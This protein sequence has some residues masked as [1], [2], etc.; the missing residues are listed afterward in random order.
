MLNKSNSPVVWIIVK[1][2][3]TDLKLGF[4]TTH[5][6]AKEQYSKIRLGQVKHL[7]KVLDKL[8][9]KCD[10]IICSGDF[11]G[12]P[13]E[14]FYKV[15]TEQSRM[16]SSYKSVLSGEPNW[17]TWKIRPGIGNRNSEARRCIDYVFYRKSDPNNDG[18]DLDPVQILDLPHSLENDKDKLPRNDYP[19][20]HLSL[21]VR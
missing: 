14:P 20:D 8:A 11:N 19:S 2:K 15:M 16:K 3:N 1:D 6:K 10:A 18:F 17:T 7:A 12:E 13:S 5:L 9:P 21:V 4:F